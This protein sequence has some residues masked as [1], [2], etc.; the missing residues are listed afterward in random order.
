MAE[1]IT[2]ARPYAKAVFELA[3]AN[4]T[5]EEWAN[6]LKTLAC[7]A[8]DPQ[9]ATLL[10][11][12][13]VSEKQ[14]QAF[15]AQINQKFLPGLNESLHKELDNFLRVLIREKRLM[16]LPEIYRRYQALISAQRGIKTINVT[17][18]FPLDADR[19]QKLKDSLGRHLNSQVEV[20]FQEDAGLIG[21]VLIRCG[22]WVMDGSI[23][24]K[25]QKLR[26]NL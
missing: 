1:N 11:N 24:G 12:P 3:R 6:I 16:V 4:S 2:L 15:F 5:W 18:A 25:L 7:I 19:R 10:D 22:N 26:D 13:L 21:G 23:K 20:H 14:L 8:E 17:S 9:A